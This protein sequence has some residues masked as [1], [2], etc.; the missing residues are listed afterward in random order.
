MV[1]SDSQVTAAF[2]VGLTSA[3][4]FATANALQ[5]QAAGRVPESVEKALRVLAHLAG[6]RVWLIA[7]AVSFSAMLLH[8]VALRLGSLALVQP[9]ML[10][11]VVL[12][13]PLR[14]ALER[15]TPTPSELRA[16]STTVAGLALFVVSTNPTPSNSSAPLAVGA[17]F[18]GAC[19]AIALLALRLSG[20]KD[21]GPRRQA[22]LLGAG[23]GLMFGATAGLLKAI[24]GAL[25]SGRSPALVAAILGC[26]VVAGLLGVA[27]NQRAYQ[28]A[29]LAFSMP[30]VNVVDIL[31][32]VVFGV[33]VFGESPAHG[34]AFLVLQ[35]T[36]LVV[37]TIGLRQISCL[38]PSSLPAGRL[39]VS[40]AW[41]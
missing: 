13:V 11:G 25:T 14:A 41:S 7:T 39:A 30:L 34:V 27:M 35:G 3:A 10:V 23:A 20:G 37:M 19:L 40:E 29:P 4:G 26:L 36:G 12:A 5:H 2:A 18:V 16:V 38:E 28:I 9:L 21:L 22:A 15:K 33:V 6:Q 24:G 31:V 17:A 8:A 32:A 1:G